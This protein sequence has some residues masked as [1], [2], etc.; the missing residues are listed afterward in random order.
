MRLLALILAALLY[1]PHTILDAPPPPRCNCGHT[2]DNHT[3]TNGPGSQPTWC[4]QCG[5]SY[6]EKQP[7]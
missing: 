7:A 6:P 1:R 3:A 4:H 2:V 5:C